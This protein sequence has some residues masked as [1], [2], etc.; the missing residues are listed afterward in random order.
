[1]WHPQSLIGAVEQKHGISG[2]GKIGGVESFTSDQLL[3]RWADIWRDF[4]NNNWRIG[5]E[6]SDDPAAKTKLLKQ[7]GADK[8]PAEWLWTNQ[9]RSLL[10]LAWVV[11]NFDS[12][13]NHAV[14]ADPD[15]FARVVSGR[16]LAE[17]VYFM[18]LW[19]DENLAD[20]VV[21]GVPNQRALGFTALLAAARMLPE[22]TRR[23]RWL[24]QSE[25]SVL[26]Y[27]RDNWQP[28][29]SDSELSYNYNGVLPT[30]LDGVI[31]L[32]RSGDTSPPFLDELRHAKRYRELF[33]QSLNTP[34]G[35][36]V[37]CKGSSEYGA[38]PVED[39]KPPYAGSIAFPW[40]GLYLL[41][42]GWGPEALF[43]SIVSPRRGNGHEADHAN[44]LTLEAYG[45]R[46]LIANPG[47]SLTGPGLYTA[48]SWG[49]CTV[50]VDGLGQN[51]FTLPRQNAYAEPIKARWHASPQFD[52]AETFYTYGYRH[53]LDPRKPDR[54]L[55]LAPLGAKVTDVS[56]HTRGGWFSCAKPACFSCSM[57][58]RVRP[59][60]PTARCGSSAKTT[61]TTA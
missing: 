6:L 12:Q 30:A 41:R 4:A 44:A 55:D 40:H 18:A 35:R 14:R 20:V 17:M 53:L 49:Q 27:L 9:W 26:G 22:F 13:L 11:D 59:N 47:E 24:A 54:R 34:W 36:Q 23:Q 5:M 32:Y 1:M 61:R 2:H 46:I 38:Q 25:K 15:G 48:S 39:R 10:P 28:D 50:N 37:M 19:P 21:G 52:F 33:L 16:P 3:S 7:C 45:R 57:K 56:Q 29:G 31:R 51:R 58:S 43:A 42:K 60:T 8:P